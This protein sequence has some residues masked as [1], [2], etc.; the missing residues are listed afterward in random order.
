MDI[1]AVL[2]TITDWIEVNIIGLLGQGFSFL[3]KGIDFLPALKSL[4]DLF[5]LA[6]AA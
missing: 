4:F 6:F 5:A 2:T 3:T 1:L